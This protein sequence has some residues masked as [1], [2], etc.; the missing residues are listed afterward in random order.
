MFNG[1]MEGARHS[2]F[3]HD[4]GAF[5]LANYTIVIWWYDM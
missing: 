3:V 5:I 2:F 1:C 4:G